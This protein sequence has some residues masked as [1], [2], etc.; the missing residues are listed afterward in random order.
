M[1]TNLTWPSQNQTGN[2]KI[3]KVERP[4]NTSFY[5]NLPAAIAEAAEVQKGG[6]ALVAVRADVHQIP[7]FVR[8]GGG[9]DL[10]DLNRE[11]DEALAVSRKRPDLKALDKELAAWFEMKVDGIY[12]TLIDIL[13]GTDSLLLDG[14]QIGKF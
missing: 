2:V 4:T 14:K 12:F 1:S 7:L 10:G 5:V 3:Q 6:E 8:E 13:A 11:Y 9:I